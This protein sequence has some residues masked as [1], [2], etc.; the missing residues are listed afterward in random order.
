[1]YIQFELPPISLNHVNDPVSMPP[2]KQ[3]F[4]RLFCAALIVVIRT[5]V[6]L[7][8]SASR[9]LPHSLTQTDQTK[10][11]RRGV[12]RRS[13]PSSPRAH[14]ASPRR[15]AGRL[16]ATAPLSPGGRPPLDPLGG[17]PESRG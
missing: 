17:P 2:S 7:G 15:F 11:D 14:L 10:P 12:S 5:A 16:D 9:P 1:M 3:S 8:I 13:E 6:V 4:P